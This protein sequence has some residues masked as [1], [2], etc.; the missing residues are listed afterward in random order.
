[1]LHVNEQHLSVTQTTCGTQNGKDIYWLTLQNKDLKIVVT[2]LGCSILEI[3]APDR[4]GVQKN[5][6]AGLKDIKEYTN[7]PHYLG[8]VIGRYTNRIAGGRFSLDGEII[9][10]SVNDGVN[11]LHGGVEGFNSKLWDVAGL[12]RREQE[13]GVVFEYRSPHGEEG[14]PGNLQVKVQY[15]LDDRNRF[16]ISYHAVTDRKTPVSVTNHTYFNLTGFEDPLILDHIL[17]IRAS[18]YTEKNGNNIPTGRILK[19]AG[20]ALDFSTPVRIGNHIDR[21]PADLGFDHNYIL[22]PGRA[23]EPAAELYEPVSG[24][25]VRLY[26]DRPAM[27]LYTANRWDGTITGRQGQLYRQHGGVAME[28]QAFPDSPN[29]PGFPDVILEPG[30]VYETKTIFEFDTCGEGS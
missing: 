23:D 9:K 16:T 30:Q 17:H 19:L 5:I 21:F 2:N 26:T 29:Q 13:A 24:R 3:E 12:I 8:C 10:L 15:L 25:R 4:N 11:H 7:N 28:T 20:T 6:V 27:Q 1:M 18:A 22:D 14:Y